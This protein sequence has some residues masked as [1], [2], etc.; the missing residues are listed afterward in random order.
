[1]EKYTNNNNDE[2]TLMRHQLE[3][4]KQKL[5]REVTINE[6]S[7]RKMQKRNIGFIS[8]YLVFAWAAIPVIALMFIGIKYMFGLSWAV[9]LVVIIGCAIDAY[10]DTRFNR[11]R[12]ADIESMSLIDMSKK[13]LWMK[14]M[15]R[16]QLRISLPLL[17]IVVVWLLI[18][19]YYSCEHGLGI[20]PADHL[21]A[22]IMTFCTTFGAI[23]GG[24]IGYMIYRRMQ[25][26]SD[27]VIEQIE[28]M[29]E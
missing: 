26:D 4:L 14:H 6:N 2:L 13:L 18:E 7:V 11:M 1:M 17:A 16:K 9:T 10:C 8:K 19:L 22:V 15:R 12:M 27:D 29:N 21:M 28:A 5:D 24:I 23:V 3:E 20:F 25:H